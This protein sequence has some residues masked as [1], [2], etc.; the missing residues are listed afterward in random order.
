MKNECSWNVADQIYCI[1]LNSRPDRLA[2]AK[3]E[4][5]KVG[6]EKVRFHFA[7]KSPEGGKYGCFESHWTILRE[8]HANNVNSVLIF[9]DD[10][11][12]QGN[13]RET[14][15]QV[16]RTIQAQPDW[17]YINIGGYPVFFESRGNE[18]I[19]RGKTLMAHAVL[20]SRRGIESFLS[21][22][23]KPDSL[24]I[25]DAY[26]CLFRSAFL[27]TK[28]S[29][30]SQ[31]KKQLGSDINWECVSRNEPTLD[32]FVQ[33]NLAPEF[34]T[35]L[36][37]AA[38]RFSFLPYRL[39]PWLLPSFIDEGELKALHHYERG[40]RKWKTGPIG[41][42]GFVMLFLFALIKVEIPESFP[43]SRL[44]VLLKA[45]KG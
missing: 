16:R 19:C 14:L 9:E 23:S 29:R 30:F 2:S 25:D 15:E 18:D 17:E 40:L 5:R 20:I 28:F 35:Y 43:H 6:L 39:R 42:L 45:V 1:N 21:V 34:H 31:K 3:A 27:N 32:Q 11:H 37:N 26:M 10:I 12:I 36:A 38:Y 22:Y 33:N 7:K 8:C 41:G 4:F 24:H 13:W 44:S